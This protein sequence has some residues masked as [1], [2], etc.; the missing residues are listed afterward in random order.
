MVSLAAHVVGRRDSRVASGAQRLWSGIEWTVEPGRLA[1]D[2]GTLLDGDHN[3]DG[4]VYL[5]K[6]AIEGLTEPENAETTG[7]RLGTLRDLE[8][9]LFGLRPLQRQVVFMC[10]FE[11]LPASAVACRLGLSGRNS[12]Y[13]RL[14]AARAAL[15][16]RMGRL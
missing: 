6:S 12:V 14:S 13:Q 8:A 15:R 2:E 1:L 5:P 7:V 10:V 3:G 9:A 11:A 16:Q 4:R